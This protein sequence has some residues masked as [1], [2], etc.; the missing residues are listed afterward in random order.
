MCADLRGGHGRVF[1]VAV[2]TAPSPDLH[3]LLTRIL[4]IWLALTVAVPAFA[5]LPV[6]DAPPSAWSRDDQGMPALPVEAR[7][8]EEQVD[9]EESAHRLDE[10]RPAPKA[11]A[12][13]GSAWFRLAWLPRSVP[14]R[15]PATPLQR[16]PGHVNV[17]VWG[18]SLWEIG[19]PRRA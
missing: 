5:V 17:P 2:R 11:R 9:E 3:A 10:A 18:A 7:E 1:P 12:R 19:P 14:T 16:A 15:P 4:G 8:A 6:P 13:A